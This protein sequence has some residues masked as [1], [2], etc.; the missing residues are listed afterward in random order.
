M[1]QLRRLGRNLGDERLL[2]KLKKVGDRLEFSLRTGTS[3]PG[4]E[5]NEKELTLLLALRAKSLNKLGFNAELVDEGR[6]L[7]VTMS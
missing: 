7:I 2:E 4:T 6:K 5:A 3:E 1:S